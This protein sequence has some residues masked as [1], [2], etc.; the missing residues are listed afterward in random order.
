MDYVWVDNYG[1]VAEAS[2]ESS[3]LVLRLQPETRHFVTLA[4]LASFPCGWRR[5]T[6][7]IWMGMTRAPQEGS[8]MMVHR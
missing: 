5:P 7:P 4:R 6:P 1:T 8:T 2:L 3:R